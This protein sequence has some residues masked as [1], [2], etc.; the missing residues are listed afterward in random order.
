[1][2]PLPGQLRLVA[3]APAGAAV[4]ALLFLG[5]SAT[6]NRNEAWAQSTEPYRTLAQGLKQAVPN[7]SNGSRIIIY[8]GVWNGFPLW[9]N[10]VARTIYKDESIN[11]INVPRQIADDSEGPKRKNGDIVLVFADGK[12]LRVPAARVL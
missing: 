8:Y 5:G 10:A 3:L 2:I 6:V 11:V 7:T 9:P 12:F 4:A 1:A